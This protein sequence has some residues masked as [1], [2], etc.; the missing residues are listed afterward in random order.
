MTPNHDS[1]SLLSMIASWYARCPKP[2]TLI[3]IALAAVVISAAQPA[4]TIGVA[5]PVT[6]IASGQ[7]ARINA[8]NMGTS[9]SSPEASC[10]VAM[11]FLDL[12]GAVLK[13]ATATITVTKAASLDLAYPAAGGPSRMGLRA[14]LLFSAI[15]GAPPGPDKRDQFD[16]SNI[17]PSMEIFDNVTGRSSVILTNSQP[18]LGL[19]PRSV[20]KSRR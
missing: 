20:A 17:V 6:T 4:P 19:D 11:R 7:T 13:E 12:Q 18:I 8:L 3:V 2:L 1:A 16:C 9:G 5:L 14:E 10:A 15:T